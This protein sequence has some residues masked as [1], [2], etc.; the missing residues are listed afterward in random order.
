MKRG[1]GCYSSTRK[2]VT[3]FFWRMQQEE[4]NSRVSYILWCLKKQY[5]HSDLWHLYTSTTHTP[6]NKT[7]CSAA[8]SEHAQILGCCARTVSLCFPALTSP[9]CLLFPLI[10]FSYSSGDFRINWCTIQQMEGQPTES[11]VRINCLPSCYMVF[12]SFVLVGFMT[13]KCV[14]ITPPGKAS[15]KTFN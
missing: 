14:C 6:G 5:A 10:R 1:Y 12:L 8:C 3:I 7:I 2:L 13:L 15:D 11:I 4:N 9:S